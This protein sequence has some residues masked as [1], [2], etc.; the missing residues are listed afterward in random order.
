MKNRKKI[1]LILFVLMISVSAFAQMDNAS[2]LLQLSDEFSTEWQQRE[3]R[4]LEYTKVNSISKTFESGGVIYQMVDVENG[5]PVYYKT[6][7]LGAAITTRANQIWPGGETGLELTGEGYY[8]LGQWDAGSVLVNHQEFT[9]QGISRVT[10]MDGSTP[11]HSHATHVAGTMVAAGINANAKGMMYGGNLKAWEWSNDDAEMAAAAAA[12]LE[13][14]NHSYGVVAGWDYNNGNW[15]WY[16]NSNISATEDYRFGFY[17]G[18]ARKVD[19]IAYNAPN[20]LI[21][22]SAGNDR[23]D[24]PSDAGTGNQP[25]KDGGEDGYDCIGPKGVAKNI[26]TVGAVYQVS[27]YTDPDDVKMS[28]FSCWGPA[29]DGRIKPDIVG[30]GVDVFSTTNVSNTSYELLNGT[31]MSSPNVSGSMAL[32]QLHYQNIFGEAMRASTLKALVIHSADEA[33]EHIGPDYIFGWGLMNTERAADLISDNEGQNVIDELTLNNGE[34]FSREVFVPE[35]KDLRVTICWTDVPGTPTS[36][37]LN[38]ISPMLV[39]DLD[40]RI[41]GSDNTTYYPYSLDRDNPSAAATTEGKNYVDN[42]EM[43]FAENLPEGNYS[44]I[45]DHDGTLSFGAQVFSMIISGIDEY[46]ELPL[47]S[48]EL[49]TPINGDEDAFI[50][51]KLVWKPAL[52]ASSYDVYLGT[53]GGGVSIPTNIY[54]GENFPTNECNILYEPGTTYYISVIPKNNLGIAQGCD[55]IWSFTTMFPI[56]DYPYIVDAEELIIPEIP[57]LWQY[58]SFTDAKWGKLRYFCTFRKSVFVMLYTVIGSDKYDF[59]TWLISPPLYLQYGNEYNFQYFFRPL[60]GGTTED[61]ALYWGNQPVPEEMTNVINIIDEPVS[62]WERNK[63]SI[64]S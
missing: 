29:D 46:T 19:Q 21:V 43:V 35:G 47:C 5:I 17:D 55:E 49:I 64:Y 16:G 37:Q 12:G 18:S 11:T 13:I 40:L 59:D 42:V 32:L 51:Q 14:S 44:I 8:Q 34:T 28:D 45:V 26:L 24:G 20:Y 53:D 23:G 33:G 25:E 30:K 63:S 62:G 57:N 38:P 15:T 36:P 58:Q 4:V 3:A 61:I 27:D 1:L 56:E 9:D 54:N 31:S 60:L 6:H 48:D 39:N 2:K 52:F 50:N 10:M 22:K 7:N 41:V